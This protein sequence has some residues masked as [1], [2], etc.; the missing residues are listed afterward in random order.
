MTEKIIWLTGLSGSGK[1]TIAKFISKKLKLMKFKIIKI[2]GDKYL[3]LIHILR[4][5]ET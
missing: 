5:H 2:D 3:S 4:A 1:T